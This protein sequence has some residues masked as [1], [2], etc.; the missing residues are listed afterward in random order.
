LNGACWNHIVMAG[1]I[2]PKDGV[3]SVHLRPGHHGRSIDCF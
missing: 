2:R 1:H 3:A